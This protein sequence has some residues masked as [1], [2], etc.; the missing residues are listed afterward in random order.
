VTWSCRSYHHAAR[1]WPAGHQVP[2]TKPTCL[3]HTC[4]PHRQRPF[5]LVLHLH[6]HQS[7]RNLHL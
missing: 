2:Q 3:L 1:T 7:S 4:R 6:L 5:A